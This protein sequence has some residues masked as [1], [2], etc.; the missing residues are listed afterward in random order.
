MEDPWEAR[1]ILDYVRGITQCSPQT[2]L[3]LGCG[4]GVLVSE[5]NR[6][7][8]RTYGIDL[9]D[10]YEGDRSPFV[11]ADARSLPFRDELF[12]IVC[13]NWAIDDMKRLQNY[14]EE[15]LKKI[16]RETHRVLRSGGYFV[17]LPRAFYTLSWLGFEDV[18]S[19]IGIY[20]KIRQ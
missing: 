5:W 8:I 9:R 16:A 4:R 12:D 14:Q 19:F 15:A 18:K 20:R 10:V 2:A 1:N 11:I 3:E 17:T 13:D 7:K 6:L